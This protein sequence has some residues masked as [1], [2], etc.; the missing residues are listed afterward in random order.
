MALALAMISASTT[1]HAQG[2]GCAELEQNI[3]RARQSG[4]YAQVVNEMSM[5]FSAAGLKTLVMTPDEAVSCAAAGT[6]DVLMVIDK[7]LEAGF[8]EEDVKK[9]IARHLEFDP[10]KEVVPDDGAGLGPAR[11]ELN[12]FGGVGVYDYKFNSTI[13]SRSVTID[14]G[15]GMGG[16]MSLGYLFTPEWEMDLSAG[17]HV[18][19]GDS[20]DSEAEGG[21]ERYSALLMLKYRFSVS[22][23]SWVK[24]G[25]GGGYFIPVFYK[26]EMP[27]ETMEIDYAS[28]PVG[29]ASLEYEMLV[30]PRESHAAFVLG[31]R[32]CSATYDAEAYRVDGVDQPVDTLDTGLKE[33]DGSGTELIVGIVSYF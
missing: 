33:L 11:F 15:G 5:A 31:V 9:G 22:K 25:L 27:P 10:L 4:D 29:V 23:D 28:A 18:S 26:A 17:Y 21:F 19:S 24:L 7:A 30:G 13:D 12:F 3:W 14:S 1:A 8:S 2:G 32:Y 20:D 16:G 6:G